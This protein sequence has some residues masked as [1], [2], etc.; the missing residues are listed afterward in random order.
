MNSKFFT[1]WSQDQKSPNVQF[2]RVM[3]IVRL[4]RGLVLDCPSFKFRPWNFIRGGTLCKSFNLSEPQ[5][6]HQSNKN[7]SKYIWLC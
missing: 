6:P 7:N 5:F 3:H 2:S 1:Y 4:I